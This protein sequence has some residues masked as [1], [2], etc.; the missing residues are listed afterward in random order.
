ARGFAAGAVPAAVAGAGAPAVTEPADLYQV[1]YNHFAPRE[2]DFR[3]LGSTRPRA[4]DSGMIVRRGYVAASW[5]DLDR[6][7]MVFSVAKS[8][9]STVAAIAVDDGFIVD[10]HRPVGELVQTQHFQG[11]HNSQVTWHH[12][13]QHTSEWGGTLWDIPDWADRPEGD[14]PEAWPERPLQTPGT[15]FKYNDVR[16]NL[17]AYGLLEVLRE[18]LP[19]VLR[20][21]IMD[22]IGA[23]RSWRWE[24]YRN[25]WVAVDGRQVQSVSG[26]GH[27]GGGMFISTADLA[28]FGLLFQR[29]G[30]WQGQQLFDEAWID[31]LREPTEVM[32]AHGYLWWLN[33]GRE[34]IPRAPES[35]YWAAGFGGNFVYVDEEHELVIVLRWIPDLE[36]VVTRILDALQDSAP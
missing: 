23:S 15:R 28:R 9:L 7:D 4:S 18:P 26:G 5:G 3:I 13:L 27:F 1:V 29:R 19:V 17:L 36:G 8:F 31:A 12:L 35:A 24:G 25:S 14:D 32:P 11:R 33:T 6:A 21:R 20:E 16:I 2:P 34:R 30:A 10:L 22:P